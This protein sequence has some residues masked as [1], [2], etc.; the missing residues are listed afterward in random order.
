[1]TPE[2]AQLADVRMARA[3]LDDQEVELID[4]ARQA[5]ATWVQIAV[6]L[7]LASRQAAEQRRQ[8]LAA[9][10]RS[11]RHDL[12][13][14]YSP[15]IVALRDA[16]SQLQRWIDADRR[17]DTRFPRAALVRS[18]AAYAL[19]AAPGSLY[20]LASHVATDL[21]DVARERL[22]IPAQIAASAII[23]ALSTDS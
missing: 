15:R 11:R 9:A 23:S 14:S 2:L 22:P 20:A 7:G 13:L 4:R 16:V 3:Q 5:G 1:M 18:C 10:R 19:E 6:A 21:S 17:W 8:R 12:D